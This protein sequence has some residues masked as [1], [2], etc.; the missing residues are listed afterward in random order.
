MIN[1]SKSCRRKFAWK[2]WK[3]IA[4]LIVGVALA[5]VAALS[6]FLWF[7]G[8]AQSS[9]LVPSR[10]GGWSVGHC[11]TFFLHLLFW[12]ILLVAIPLIVAAVAIYY[13]WWKRLPAEER[14]EYRSIKI[15]GG[16][17]RGTKGGSGFSFVVN[18]LFLLK[19][20]LDHNWNTPF[21]TWT[22]DYVVESYLWALAWIL[23]I[24]G[25]PL[26]IGG[27][28]WLSKAAKT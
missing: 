7:V 17:S 23:I 27:I 19:V 11:V 6:V 12:E 2:H 24:V 28:W 9:G 18:L 4:L 20:Y 14:A 26:A 25:I 15:F 21:S 22:L 13:L 10:L 3:A 1:E 16:R 5:V 8:D